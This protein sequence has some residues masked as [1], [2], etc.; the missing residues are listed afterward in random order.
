M[1]RFCRMFFT[2]KRS[3]SAHVS[4]PLLRFVVKNKSSVA[5]R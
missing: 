3:A 2:P 5:A 1:L 4:F